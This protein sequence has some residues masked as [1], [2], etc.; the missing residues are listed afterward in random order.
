MLYLIYNAII[1]NIC[2]LLRY[3]PHKLSEFLHECFTYPNLMG[4]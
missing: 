1:V 2:V 3:S 4:K